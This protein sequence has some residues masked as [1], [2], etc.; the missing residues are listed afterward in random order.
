MLISGQSSRLDGTIAVSMMVEHD[1]RP[2]S[3]E[4]E[5]DAH[6]DPYACPGDDSSSALEGSLLGPA[7]RLRHIA[8]PIECARVGTTTWIGSPERATASATA[9]GEAVLPRTIS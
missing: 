9:P 5:P 3:G 1:G 2:T 6:A 4:S 8:R 7:G